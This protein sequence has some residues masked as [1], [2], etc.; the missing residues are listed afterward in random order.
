MDR[1]CSLWLCPIRHNLLLPCH[2]PLPSMK[3]QVCRTRHDGGGQ[4]RRTAAARFSEETRLPSVRNLARNAG[5]PTSRHSGVP[6]SPIA[7]CVHSMPC[8]PSVI[9]T[10]IRMSV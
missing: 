6:P 7:P 5:L 10:A 1:Y 2:V 9:Q 8:V 3:V 4:P